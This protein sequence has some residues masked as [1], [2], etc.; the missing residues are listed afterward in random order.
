MTVGSN[1]A[2]C[3][4]AAVTRELS[5][6][7]WVTES[8]LLVLHSG[9]SPQAMLFHRQLLCVGIAG[10][11]NLD[12]RPADRSLLERLIRMLDYRGPDG[13]GTY[14]NGSIGLAHNRLSIIDIAGG[15][16]PMQC[17][18]GALWITFN[19]EIFNFIEL[20]EEL[21]KKGH[22]FSTRSDTEVIL[23]LTRN[24]VLTASST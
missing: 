11:L 18:D 8:L 9:G 17:D 10:F 2:T 20:R 21:V 5:G 15:H 7:G 6:T 24:T 4:A 14:T 3:F 1:T 19:G 22:R 13:T 12:G 16:Q 23:R